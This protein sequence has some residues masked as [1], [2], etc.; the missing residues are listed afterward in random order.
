MKTLILF[1]LMFTT[2]L[3][4]SAQKAAE[5]KQIQSTIVIFFDGLATM[6][7]TLM[8]EQVTN[9]MTLHEDGKIWNVDT[10]VK[11]INPM[12]GKGYKREN[13]FDFIKTTQNGN[14][15]WVSYFNK[16]VISFGDKTRNIKWLESAVLVKENAKWKIAHMNST[17]LKAK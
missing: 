11:F 14:V 7:E 8:R 17:T 12:K 5:Q 3:F 2:S 4:C 15:A 6:N 1:S 10:L 9:D 16:A 13:E